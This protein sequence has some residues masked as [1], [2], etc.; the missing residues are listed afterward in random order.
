[1]NKSQGDRMKEFNFTTAPWSIEEI[2]EDIYALGDTDS[3]ILICNLQEN[4]IEKTI[5]TTID[6]STIRK[7]LYLGKDM[8]LCVQFTGEILLC[9][10][11]E[12]R[13]LLIRRE[14][15]HII[16]FTKNDYMKDFIRVACK[17]E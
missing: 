7:L 11:H 6:N 5:R 1:M 13:I 17:I 9:L 12:E 14:I 10:Y 3:Q 8:L 16:E 2:S 15:N 4:I